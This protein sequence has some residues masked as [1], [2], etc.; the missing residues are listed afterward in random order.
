MK[1]IRRLSI[2]AL[3]ISTFTIGCGKATPPTQMFDL[4]GKVVAVN[5]KKK[6]VTLNHDRIP[7]LLEPRKRNFD[8]A[9]DDLLEGLK[10]GDTVSGKLRV[11]P[12]DYTITELQKH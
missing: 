1:S 4:Q 5:L 3:L 2:A 6:S 10:A 12:G 8:V 11:A 7:D 9:S